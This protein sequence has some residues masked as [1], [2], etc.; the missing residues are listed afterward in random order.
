MFKGGANGGTLLR[1]VQ[2]TFGWPL[3][4]RLSRKLPDRKKLLRGD[5]PKSIAGIS[6]AGRHRDHA[7]TYIFR[8]G[9]DFKI[10]R[11]R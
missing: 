3:A 7:S 5:F 1:R 9:T 2:T 6:F 11:W 10:G 4:S 8:C